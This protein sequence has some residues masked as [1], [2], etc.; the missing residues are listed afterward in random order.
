V[1]GTYISFQVPL[2]NYTGALAINNLGQCAGYYYTDTEEHGFRRDADGTLTYPI[3]APGFLYT[4]LYGI[5]DHGWMV[6]EAGNSTGIS[7]G[8]LFR[9]LTMAE[10]YSYPGATLGTAFLGINNH[11]LICGSYVDDAGTHGLLVKAVVT[12]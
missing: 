8:V 2:T 11:G 1:A 4:A 5:N 6:G 3:D 7:Q 10:T 12:E 9:S